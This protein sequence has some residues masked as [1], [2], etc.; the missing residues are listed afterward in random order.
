MSGISTSNGL[1]FYQQM[2]S[3]LRCAVLTLI[4]YLPW[5]SQR[6]RRLLHPR[7]NSFRRYAALSRPY[8][9]PF[10]LLLSVGCALFECLPTATESH[11]LRAEM[12]LRG[13]SEAAGGTPGGTPPAAGGAP[14]LLLLSVGCALFECLP[15]ATKSHALRADMPQAGRRAATLGRRRDATATP[16]RPSD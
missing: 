9:A 12:P 11:A 1:I 2:F 10:L 16:S 6:R 14:F 8:R 5:F 15:T 3:C 13:S 7:L 4:S